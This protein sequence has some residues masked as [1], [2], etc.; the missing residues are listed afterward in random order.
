MVS[1]NNFVYPIPVGEMTLVTLPG[2]SA[3]DIALDQAGNI[4]C[5]LEDGN[6][7]K[8]S[9]DLKSQSILVNTGGRPLGLD[10]MPDGRLLVCDSERGLLAVDLESAKV[11]VLLDQ[12]NGIKIKICNNPSVAKDGT[13]YFSDSSQRY[14]LDNIKKDIIENIPTGRLIKIDQTE[15][16]QVLLEGLHFANGVI[17]APDESFVLVA[18]TG[19]RRIQ[20]YWLK[21]AKAGKAE[22]FIDNMPGM[23]DNLSLGSDGLYWCALPGIA[24]PRLELIHRLPTPIRKLITNLPESIQPEEQRNALMI[25]FNSEGRYIHYY[26]GDPLRFHLVTGV[27]EHEG[28]LYAA[29]I[30]KNAIAKIKIPEV[31]NTAFIRA[32]EAT[33][34]QAI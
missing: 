17:L 34:A 26:E 3:E 20:R 32:G 28:Y 7:V 6:I 12:I 27:K 31:K 18:E 8:I 16:P 13:I 25:A 5:G 15:K 10:W 4:Y 2:R 23:P 11:A 33:P 19:A 14:K 29:S 24:D 30:E 21:G 22:I 9:Q 1:H